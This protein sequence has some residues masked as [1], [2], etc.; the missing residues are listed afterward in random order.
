M[1]SVSNPDPFSQY[2]SDFERALE[3]EVLSRPL[4]VTIAEHGDLSPYL[5]TIAITRDPESLGLNFLAQGESDQMAR[6]VMGDHRGVLPGSR[7]PMP[8]DVKGH[9]DSGASVIINRPFARQANVRGF[10]TITVNGILNRVDTSISE[11]SASRLTEWLVVASESRLSFVRATQR[12]WDSRFARTRL[13]DTTNPPK[14]SNPS[15]YTSSARD[16]LSIKVSLEGNET[17]ILFGNAHVHG[18][19]H[20]WQPMFLEIPAASNA[21]FDER[22]IM[23]ICNALSFALGS[24][25]FSLGR[26][27][28]NTNDEPV[29]HR[30]RSPDVESVA[31][32]FRWSSFPPIEL[33]FPDFPHMIDES[34]VNRLV[35]GFLDADTKMGLDHPLWI[36]HVADSSPVSM[37]PAHLGAAIESL[38]DRYFDS[39]S[40]RTKFFD[41]DSWR[42][43]SAAIGDAYDQALTQLPLPD[44]SKQA[45]H[46]SAD[47]DR[48]RRAITVRANERSSA[49]RFE[50]FF[51]AL[52]LRT[53]P[54]EKRALASRNKPAHGVDTSGDAT[55]QVVDDIHALRTLFN[56]IILRLSEISSYRDYSKV[57]WPMRNIAEQLGGEASAATGQ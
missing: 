54:I 41:D 42:T 57:G 7:L 38:R 31:T 43:I 29:S 12:H 34:V 47:R 44:D 25:V 16:H 9:T 11:Q 20:R 45:M 26:T 51:D 14:W 15:R 52:G 24:Q 3:W 22:T 5:R 33:G 18:W 1:H 13:D 49:L 46:L 28:F 48:V 30:A 37:Q 53:G 17:E 55:S 36:K 10:R 50:E 2:Q 56:R 39:S 40:K 21:R 8:R 19:P 4:Q 35:R 6:D 23:N 32:P 27:V